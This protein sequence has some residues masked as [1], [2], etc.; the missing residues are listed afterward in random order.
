MVTAGR[1]LR[2]GGGHDWV[3]HRLQRWVG[4]RPHGRGSGLPVVFRTRPF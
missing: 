3:P 2:K 1:H 4:S